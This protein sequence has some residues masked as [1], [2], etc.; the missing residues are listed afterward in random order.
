MDNIDATIKAV[1]DTADRVG[2]PALAREAGVPY[3]T[4]QTF[5]KRKWSHKSLDVLKKLSK[6]S[7]RLAANDQ[8][9]SQERAA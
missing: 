3:T 5:A 4:L 8:A 9:P 7:D 6:A 2:L 1:R